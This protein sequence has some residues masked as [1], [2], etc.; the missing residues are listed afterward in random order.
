[1]GCVFVVWV[2]NNNSQLW[3]RSHRLLQKQADG[4]RLADA[5]RS[6]NRKVPSHQFADVDLRRDI[7]VLAQ[8]ADLDALPAAKSVDSSE[9]IRA[10]SVRRSAQG[11]KRAH[12]AMEQRRV[13]K[14][15]D[16]FPIQ[17]NC[18]PGS[19]GLDF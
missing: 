1:M 3:H 4:G 12:P 7:F 10:D 15:G 6:Q 11:G 9:V 5:G 16:N 18:D 19:V 17:L 2:E 13:I 14:I 8:P